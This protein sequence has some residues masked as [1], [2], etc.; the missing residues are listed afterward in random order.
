VKS[1]CPTAE[2][3]GK[4]KKK[5]AKRITTKAKRISCS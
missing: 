3:P 5:D 2:F 1:G 4:M